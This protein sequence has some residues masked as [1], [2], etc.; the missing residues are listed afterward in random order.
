MGRGG[1]TLIAPTDR[2]ATR[3]Y[4]AW[5][6]RGQGIVGYLGAGEPSA[7]AP[8]T[9]TNPGA[10]YGTKS[11]HWDHRRGGLFDRAMLPSFQKVP[12][13]EV[14]VIAN[15]SRESGERVQRASP[16]ISRRVASDF[17]EVLSSP[18]VDAG[19]HRLPPVLHKEATFAALDAG[20]HVLCQT[21]ISTTV[22]EARDMQEYA[23]EAR[24]RGLHT[25][26]VPPAPFYRGSRFVEH[27]VQSGYLG[28]LRHVMGFNV[29]ASFAD[30]N[31]PLSAGRSDRDLSGSSTRC[32]SAY[33]RRDGPLDWP[34]DQR[35]RP[36]Q[37][38]RPGAPTHRQRPI[39]QNP[40]PDEVP[41]VDRGHHERSADVERRELLGAIRRHPRR[42]VRVRRDRGVLSQGDSILAGRVGDDR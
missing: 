42:A 11:P 4:A 40:F 27:L 1:E 36:A 6:S 39:V 33:L 8:I 16:G 21:R 5:L 38:L 31:T 34:R 25:M 23:E 15:R 17:R 30:P 32:S 29:N 37:D 7:A 3:G 22:A 10:A 24:S 35:G 26:L 2:M 14:T 28:Q 18:D 41:T 13:V 9:K 12:D 20:K 19:L